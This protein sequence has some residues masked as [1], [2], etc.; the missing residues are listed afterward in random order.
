MRAFIQEDSIAGGIFPVQDFAGEFRNKYIKLWWETSTDM[1]VA[2]EEKAKA[3][4]SVKEKQTDIFIRNMAQKLKALPAPGLEQVSWREGFKKSTRKFARETLGFSE[5][6]LDIVFGEGFIKSTSSFVKQARNFAPE[7]KLEDIFQAIRNVWIMNSLQAFT[8][9]DIGYSNP[10]FAYSMLYPYTDNYLDSTDIEYVE[11]AEISSRFRRCLAGDTVAPSSKYEKDIFTLVQ[12][13]EEEYPREKYPHIYES[14]LGIHDAQQN[15]LQQQCRRSSPYERD[16]LG[17]SF[18][19]GGMSVLT[20][21]FLVG[22]RLTVEEAD[23]AFGFGIILQLAD[24]LQDVNT[25]AENGHMT[26]FSQIAGKWPLDAITNR[27]MN[28]ISKVMDSSG[29]LES[30]VSLNM[31]SLIKYNCNFLIHQAIAKNRKLFTAEYINEISKYS[32]YSYKYL[33]KLYDKLRK[34]YVFFEKGRRG[35]SLDDTVHTIIDNL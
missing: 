26:I 7:M 20:D 5:E 3:L 25:D 12:M 9:L 11:K 22:G 15:S 32:I 21:A 24:D 19:K 27:L 13:I 1:P 31:K 16:I 23:F 4:K 6:Y 18:Q 10:I 35:S 34:E 28:F 29:C 33:R 2:G 30:S 8:G 17:I 14:L